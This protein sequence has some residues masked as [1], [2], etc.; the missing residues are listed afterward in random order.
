MS[1]PL[2]RVAQGSNWARILE[3]VSAAY[4]GDVQ[5]ID[6]FWTRAP[7]RRHEQKDRRSRCMARSRGDPTTK[8][9]RVDAAA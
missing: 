8:S 1:Q 7:A 3:A 6:S 4:D 2:Q 9:M 5:M